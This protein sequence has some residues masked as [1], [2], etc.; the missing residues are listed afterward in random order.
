[1]RT[2]VITQNDLLAFSFYN[3]TISLEYS[4]G[5]NYSYIFYAAENLSYL[6]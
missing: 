4:V 3:F 6:K 1:M 2:I 5:E